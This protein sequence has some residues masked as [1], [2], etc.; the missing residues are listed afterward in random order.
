[1]DYLYHLLGIRT[2]YNDE[3]VLFV[4]NFIH[5]R[6][7]LRKAMLN[8]ISVIFVYP[9][10]QLEAIS[11]V[12][13]HIINLQEKFNV[14]LI[15]RLDRLTYRQREYL[16]KEQIPF[17]VEGKQVY[18]PFMGIYLQ[19]RCNAKRTVT[20]RLLPSSQLLLLYYIYHSYREVLTSEASVELNFTPTSI[21]RASRQL[22]DMG[23]LRTRKR[24]IQKV[25]FSEQTPEELFYS[26]RKY[27]LNPVKRTIYVSK[28]VVTGDFLLSGYFAL[29]RYSTLNPPSIYCLVSTSISSLEAQS[30]K[31][32]QDMEDQCAVELWRYDPKKLSTGRSVDRLS[33]ALSLQYDQDERV[34]E[35]IEEILSYEWECINAKRF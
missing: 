12:K 19:E 25:I 35:A 13:K 22:E 23:F 31:E 1:M 2:E 20:E 3:A 27:L 30:S 11:I 7:D 18:L 9:K 26:A 5:A 17:I 21:Q 34:E 33:L 28:S 24:G 6:Y 10:T 4:P 32:L 14:P 8:G 16:I 29:S 15:L